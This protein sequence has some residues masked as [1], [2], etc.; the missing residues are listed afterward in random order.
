MVRFILVSKTLLKHLDS[1]NYSRCRFSVNSKFQNYIFGD[2]GIMNVEKYCRNIEWVYT[3][4]KI[5]I[6]TNP[7]FILKN[8]DDAF[9]AHLCLLSSHV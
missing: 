9:Q 3:G 7:V 1:T 5:T 8:I 4:R 6:L 2:S